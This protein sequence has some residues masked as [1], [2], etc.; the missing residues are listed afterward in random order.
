MIDMKGI[1][2]IL[3]AIGG[4]LGTVL[5]Y[6][7]IDYPLMIGTLPVNVLIANVV[8]SFI[9]GMFVIISQQWNLDEK[10][11]LLVAFGFVGSFTTMSALALESSNMLDN[12]NYGLFA[13]NI[14]TNVGL[15]I[16]AIFGGRALMSAIIGTTS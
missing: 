1:E 6:K 9:L 11:A 16:A 13:V 4:T 12:M 8:G 14:I 5:R 7:I 15:S 2:I 10:Y 3:L